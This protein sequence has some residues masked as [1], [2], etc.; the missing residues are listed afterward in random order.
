MTS[1][2]TEQGGGGS[3]KMSTLHRSGKRRKEREEADNED[4]NMLGSYRHHDL[5]TNTFEIKDP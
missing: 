5:F 2:K 4:I 1:T 3:S